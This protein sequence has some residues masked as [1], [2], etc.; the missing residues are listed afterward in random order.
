MP[1]ATFGLIPDGSSQAAPA[2]PVAASAGPALLAKRL[3]V[4][5]G[6]ELSQLR[7]LTFLDPADPYGIRTA[8]GEDSVDPATGRIL[9]WQDNGAAI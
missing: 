6:V 9:A 7:E 2:L 5:Q 3:S 1:L 8:T 4:L